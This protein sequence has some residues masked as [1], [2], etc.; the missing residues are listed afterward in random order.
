MGKNYTFGEW[1]LDTRLY[2]LRCAGKPL[3]LEPKS[4]DVLL[5]LIEQRDRV[6]SNEEL[7][8]RLWPGQTVGKAALIRTVMAARRAIGDNGK[9]QWYIKTLRNRGYRFVA[10]VEEGVDTLPEQE[11]QVAL[12]PSLPRGGHLWNQAG[13]A[14]APTPPSRQQAKPLPGGTLPSAQTTPQEGPIVCPQCQQKNSV[15]ASFCGECGA[16]LV[17]VCP[18][19]GHAESPHM[20]FCSACGTLLMGS[21]P[22]TSSPESMPQS[23][24]QPARVGSGGAPSA[25]PGALEAERRHL[26]LLFC[27]LVD[28]TPSH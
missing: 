9:D 24:R 1:Q 15:R 3:E 26:T 2:E 6:V 10:P 19:C 16:H 7:I 13:A 28:S 18:A 22:G 8:E 5:Y 14:P 23:N 21:V 11:A 17:W 4:F 25:A 27:D 20:H 12:L